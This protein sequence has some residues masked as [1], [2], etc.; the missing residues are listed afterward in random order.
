MQP[1]GVATLIQMTN[2][3]G[4]TVKAWDLRPFGGEP[5]QLGL[6]SSPLPPPGTTVDRQVSGGRTIR[7]DVNT[8]EVSLVSAGGGAAGAVAAVESGT[9]PPPSV[10]PVGGPPARPGLSPF[11]LAALAGVAWALFFRRR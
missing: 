6:A 4:A 11:M 9:A 1:L 2:S 3:T 10:G 8:G 5:L 7:V